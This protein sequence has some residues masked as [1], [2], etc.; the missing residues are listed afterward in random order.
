[1][2]YVQRAL[3][4]F[5]TLFCL[6]IVFAGA[7]KADTVALDFQGF[8]NGGFNYTQGCYESGFAFKA[9]SPITITQL[10]YYDANLN[11]G[12]DKYKF[13]T[14]AVGVWNLTTNTLIGK[15]TVLSSDPVV[16]YFR[17]TALSK[18]IALNTTDTYAVAGITGSSYYTAAV[19]VSS[20]IGNLPAEINYLSV[21]LWAKKPADENG[22]D[23]TKSL[24]QPNLFT[25]GPGGEGIGPDFG[26][27]FI[28]ASAA[29]P[30]GTFYGPYNPAITAGTPSCGQFAGDPVNC[31]SGNFT[32]TI[33]D[34]SVPGRGR[35]LNL[36][37]TYNSHDAVS[38]GIGMFGAGWSSSYGAYL[39]IQSDGSVTVHQAGGAIVQ[40]SRLKTGYTAPSYVTAMLVKNKNGTYTF[41]LKNQQSDTFDKN[42]RLISQTDRNGLVT[43]LAYDAN[44]HLASVTDPA[45]RELVFT[46]G[47]NGLVSTVTDPAGRT[48]SYAYDGSG[49][50]VSVT[51]VEG[52]TTSFTYPSNHLLAITTDPMGGQVSNEYDGSNRVV[53]QADQLLNTTTFSYAT[54]IT[55]TTTVTDPNGNVSLHT[56]SSGLLISLTAGYGTPQEATWTY[57]Y[58]SNL[59]R[60]SVTDGMGNIW[61][62]AYDGKGNQIGNTDPL[63]NTVTTTYTTR[64]DPAKITDQL[65]VTTT[66]TY[67]SHGDLASSS[68]P[69]TG[70]KAAKTTYAHG[71]AKH[72][73][74]VTSITGP[75]G[76]KTTFAYDEYGNNVRTT[77]PAG[78]I[79]T[80]SF[81]LIGRMLSLV[82][83][84]GHSTVYTYNA[85]G[86]VL[87]VTDPLGHTSTNAY[88]A[89]GQ[90]ISFTD[91]DG[92]E[93]VYDYSLTGKLVKTVKPDGSVLSK[94]YDDN[95]N[96]VT[97]TDGNGNN[98]V[99]A[100]DALDRVSSV[101]DALGRTTAYAYDANGKR[102]SDTAP[103]GETITRTYDAAG[104]LMGV[105]YSNA[106]THG[107]TYQYD[108][109]GKRTGMTDGSGSSTWQYDSLGRV[110]HAVNGGGKAVSYIY[111]LR[112]LPTGITYPNNLSVT[113]IYDKA[114]RL[115][116]VKDWL[117]NT[118][119]FQYDADGNLVN[120]AYPNGWKG[121]Y[122]YD[123]ADRIT[124]IGYTKPGVT[125]PTFSYTRTN[126]GLLAGET[127]NSGPATTYSYDG[128]MRLIG[129]AG[130]NYQYDK[131]DRVTA[132]PT[133][134]TLA[135]DHADQLTTGH[136]GTFSYDQRANRISFTPS[137][138]S[139]LT[140]TYDGANRL[141]GYG[142]T[143]SY[144]YD[145]DGLRVSKTTGGTPEAY[146]WDRQATL[147][148][149]LTDGSS[150]YIYGAGH[151]PL[152]QVN[153][154]GAAFF[155]H[156]D[157]LGSIRMI[158]DSKGAE[159]AAYTYDV[160][161]NTVSSTP[162]ASNPFGYAGAYTDAESGLLYLRARYY[163]P[164]T[165]QFISKDPLF[166]ATGQAYAYAGDSPTNRVDPAGLDGCAAP[167]F[168]APHPQEAPQD[169]LPQST[170]TAL[171]AYAANHLTTMADDFVPYSGRRETTKPDAFANSLATWVDN[172]YAGYV[173]GSEPVYQRSG[174][175]EVLSGAGAV[176]P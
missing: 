158:T 101:T 81:D 100:Y 136:G 12:A 149:I 76:A 74:D 135:Y 107:V 41:T 109:T 71:N 103:D 93:T 16:G 99:F 129:V 48:V 126:A 46:T 56:F 164:A 11:G 65:G 113:R 3:G 55:N 106:Q 111:D 174:L 53:S 69:L 90:L 175:R 6:A 131:G 153:A 66:L 85:F 38:G 62:T 68:R 118:T 44:G 15:A 5:G 14:H 166:A 97:R 86:R 49:N 157:Q 110:T 124:G 105:G 67:S 165:A 35:A 33:T 134:V 43:S 1:M 20:A 161:G 121:Q 79:T 112:G 2:K 10:G 132:M 4:I 133:G 24:I 122:S 160:Y 54:G 116:S 58:D 37:R 155:Y 23:P 144:A 130:Q 123:F 22:G 40:F 141:T 115:T 18:P 154:S 52:G 159:A 88:D 29:L 96:L 140:Y 28:F 95:G 36:T 169:G 176:Q 61:K 77:D 25:W 89:K 42:G 150:Y 9:N 120:T 63:N 127:L 151:V 162:L 146:V 145:G 87:T 108:K 170:L 143:A 47:P 7:V 84:L 60:T 167:R 138:G 64:N 163:D 72:P 128:A 117:K 139:A 80:R 137:S 39:K 152:E 92:R 17:Y 147:P 173:S 82:S 50:L 21:A 168:T 119:T 94:S 73:G 8:G 172:Q 30:V 19:P 91:R 57:G 125:G 104:R 34:L 142:A 148:A 102:V 156:T 83:P 59:N 98:T 27:N 51:D 13:G 171:S 70:S 78:G 31:D 75:T 32:E 45:G 114:G 26:P